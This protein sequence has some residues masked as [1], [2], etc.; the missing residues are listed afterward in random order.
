V[1]FQS[2]LYKTQA[3]GNHFLHD[4]FSS[5][6]SFSD[7]PITWFQLQPYSD[8]DFLTRNGNQVVYSGTKFGPDLP[9]QVYLTK[10]NYIEVDTNAFSSAQTY[11]VDL[12]V[13]SSGGYVAL[14]SIMVNITLPPT[15][16][17][18]PPN[19]AL[20]L[21]NVRVDAYDMSAYQYVSPFAYDPESNSIDVDVDTSAR[22]PSCGKV[23][24][25]AIPATAFFMIIIQR[26][27]LTEADSGVYPVKVTLSD[28]VTKLKS[29]NKF[30]LTLVV[31]GK[32]FRI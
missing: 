28:P 29:V 7:C 2:G 22:T 1:P 27:V 25:Q 3:L 18:M 15:H 12:A 31:P 24:F 6:V 23:C 13:R 4:L 8:S 26:G 5:S 19:F 21:E 20:P 10:G 14:T 9:T 17:N 32:K 11:F 16:I 30:N